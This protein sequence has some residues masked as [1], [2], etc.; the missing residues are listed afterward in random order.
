[1]KRTFVKFAGKKFIT[2][3]IISASFLAGAPVVAKANQNHIIE[4]VSSEHTAT[5][6]YAGSADDAFFFDVKVNNPKGDKFTLVI[7]TTD[8]EVLYNK[9]YSDINFAKKVKI[10]KSEY[11]DGYNISIRSSNKEL[12]NDFSVS[13][14]AKTVVD[15]IVTK[16]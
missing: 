1:M 2:A 8:G 13:T 11:L 12:E 5:V 6:K 16:L 9:D 14:V 7:A 3:A 10:L 4:I 15:V